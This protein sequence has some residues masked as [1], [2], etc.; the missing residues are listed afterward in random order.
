MEQKQRGIHPQNSH[1]NYHEV[2]S[3]A[4]DCGDSIFDLRNPKQRRQLRIIPRNQRGERRR[5]QSIM[6][7]YHKQE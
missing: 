2:P 5:K 3:V 1:L 4:S 6:Q 7:P